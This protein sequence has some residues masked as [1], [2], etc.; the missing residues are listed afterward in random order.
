MTGLWVAPALLVAAPWFLRNW[1]LYGD[2]LGMALC[3]RPSTC[4]PRRRTGADTGGRCV[5]FVSVLGQVRRRGHIPMAGWV[6]VLL[7]GLTVFRAVVGLVR[8]VIARRPQFPRDAVCA[9]A[10]RAGERGAGHVA[11]LLVAPGRTRAGCSSRGR[12][13]W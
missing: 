8:L 5:W 10:A 12:R 13:A 1:R 9:A 2:P 7:A 4:A 6:Y 3:A 11:L